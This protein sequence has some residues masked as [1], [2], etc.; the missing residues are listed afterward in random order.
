MKHGKCPFCGMDDEDEFAINTLKLECGVFYRGACSCGATGPMEETK[1]EALAAWD[2]RAED[3]R[4]CDTCEHGNPQQYNKEKRLMGG[5][6]SGKKRAQ[7]RTNFGVFDLRE[8]AAK[9][10]AAIAEA[11]G[12]SKAQ[13]LRELILREYKNESLSF[14]PRQRA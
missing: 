1:E 6:G 8:V 14:N 2:A 7:V 4:R 5:Q 13:V 10:L 11:R 9:R 3:Q 12:I